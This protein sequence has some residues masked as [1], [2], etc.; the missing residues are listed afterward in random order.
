MVQPATRLIRKDPIAGHC[1][2]Y[3]GHFLR[4]EV[5]LSALLKMGVEA[6]GAHQ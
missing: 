3:A 2:V 4:K 5:S 1:W 6:R